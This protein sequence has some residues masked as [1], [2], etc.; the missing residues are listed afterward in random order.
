MKQNE[1]KT[2]TVYFACDRQNITQTAEVLRYA[3]DD[4]IFI[5]IYGEDIPY[6]Y[7]RFSPKFVD[8]APHIS[9]DTDVFKGK[10]VV[11]K[12]SAEN[13]QM[14]AYNNLKKKR[15]WFS[16]QIGQKVI[17][18]YKSTGEVISSLD[19][20]RRANCGMNV[21]LILADGFEYIPT[22]KHKE[23]AIKEATKLVVYEKL[24][25][26]SVKSN[27]IKFGLSDTNLKL[28]FDDTIQISFDSDYDFT[29]ELEKVIK[30][31]QDEII[32]LLYDGKFKKAMEESGLKPKFK[33]HVYTNVTFEIKE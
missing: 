28:N 27:F 10:C 31:K 25:L 6:M 7:R 30:Q 9:E 23:P 12:L 18:I 26:D 21:I 16:K 13:K 19:F 5:T 17:A 4:N 2:K 8:E 3:D 22:E 11:Y 32:S 29:K 14:I 1:Y 20:Y 15:N 24:C 33:L